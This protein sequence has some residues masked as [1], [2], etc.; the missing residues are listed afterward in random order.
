MA[1]RAMNVRHRVGRD[2]LRLP[3][4]HSRSRS[5][6]EPVQTKLGMIDRQNLH[7]LEPGL[8]RIAAQR[9]GP[10]DRTRSGR[11]LARHAHR[12][13]VKHAG[14]VEEALELVGGH[15]E[16]FLRLLIDHEHGAV[17]PA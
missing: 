11:S 13:T 10:E 5:L 8:T 14:G 7:P 3:R 9:V 4:R 17:G 6:E 15:G 16:T 12:Q 1:A 2:A